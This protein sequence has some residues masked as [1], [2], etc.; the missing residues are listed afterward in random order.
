MIKL[1]FVTLLT[2]LISFQTLG[3]DFE[4]IANSL[5][6]LYMENKLDS[7]Y[8]LT[9]SS[10]SQFEDPKPQSWFEN[11]LGNIDWERGNYPDA[12]L[13]YQ[14][15][16]QLSESISDSTTL[17]HAYSN[18]GLNYKKMGDYVKALFYY[19]EAMELAL[20][21]ND[22]N[23]EFE[24]KFL[25]ANLYRKIKEGGKAITA[26]NELLKTAK[27]PMRRAKVYNSIGGYYA[28]SFRY[29]SSLINYKKALYLTD[30]TAYNSKGI[31]L[32]NV[33]DALVELN[34]P[35]SALLYLKQS[36]RY[37]EIAQDSN[38]FVR[39]YVTLAS[40]YLSKRD[41]NS[42]LENL[43]SAE[44]IVARSGELPLLKEVYELYSQY[45]KEKGNPTLAFDFLEK[46]VL[47][48][49]SLLD[50]K[51][52]EETNFLSVRFDV[53][54]KEEAL[55]ELITQEEVQKASI[56]AQKKTIIALV[57]LAFLLMVIVFLIYLLFLQKKR[58]KEEV[59]WRMREQHHRIDN[60][61]S[62]LASILS[63]AARES[64]SDEAKLIAKD[65]ENRLNAMNMLHKE[66]YW[67]ADQFIVN[68]DT[69]VEKLANFLVSVYLK[70]GSI[71]NPLV[72]NLQPTN[73]SVKTAIPLSLILN[74]L[75]TNVFKH[76]MNNLKPLLLVQMRNHENEL[77]LLVED[78][79]G[80]IKDQQ[81]FKNSFGMQLIQTLTGQIK[82]ELNIIN[83][84]EGARVELKVPI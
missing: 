6:K 2:L 32:H 70:P 3:Q 64:A 81:A 26:Y 62:I 45:Y 74:E 10:M 78:N 5:R 44:K 40:A 79:G 63:L 76:G 24:N 50:I 16:I 47:V 59:S 48:N 12:I 58:E 1:L 37:K 30:S 11:L 57:I 73:V 21:L 25:I 77:F 17:L 33:G 71:Q 35:D 14:K 23:A 55:Q 39:S 65:G 15:S 19:Q 66:L 13:H 38:G 20:T 56:A 49:D 4:G 8:I 7:A 22:S 82:G 54:R 60:N 52:L 72:L 36:L 29:D 83:S 80:G 68:L 46:R 43:Q 31:Y 53:K 84:A 51:K 41:W 61:I 9:K 67:V 42:A 18:L 34:L 27:D 28:E 69:F 75:I